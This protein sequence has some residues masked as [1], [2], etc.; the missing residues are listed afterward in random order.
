[1]TAVVAVGVLAGGTDNQLP[2]AL[3]VV[4]LGAFLG[5][6]FINL[7][8]EKEDVRFL[9]TI[10]LLGITLR[11]LIALVTH[12]FLPHG[13]FALD[14][15]RYNQVGLQL[16]A[17]WRNEGSF[18]SY[19]EHTS[20]VGWYYVNGAIY[21][22][23]G[24]VPLVPAF[25][26]CLIGPLSALFIFYLCRAIFDRKSAVAAS[27]LAMFFP[28]IMLWASIN[29]KDALTAFCI[30]MVLWKTLQLQRQ[31]TVS[32]FLFL[33]FFITLLGTL[34]SYLFVLTGASVVGSLMI[35]RLQVSPRGL[36]L[37]LLLM[38]A[39]VGVYNRYGFGSEMMEAE[40]L[41]TVSYLRSSMAEGGSAYAVDAE[42]ETPMQALSYL[43]KG[44]A[45]FLLAP[46]PWQ[47]FNLR[48]ALTF[49]EMLLWYALLPMVWR[50]IRY[51]LRFHFRESV[52]L[53]S[54]AVMITLAYALVESN[55]G[56][57]Y[58]HRAQVLMVY[59]IFAGLGI[60]H[61]KLGP[62]KRETPLTQLSLG[63]RR[64][65]PA[66]LGPTPAGGEIQ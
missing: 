5:L 50:G 54:F 11:C 43:P 51:S 38:L 56:T 59:L 20:Q 19:I 27:L 3:A 34:R 37:G 23:F 57:A 8:S 40:G 63:T 24:F 25:L 41:K 35:G 47:I 15:G 48:Q 16:A 17:H 28:S 4:G 52:I 14:D 49:P 44:L 55:L 29:L 18:P 33:V 39:F 31:F 30:I 61:R 21:W 45:Y 10:F 64:A 12:Y 7:R 62:A 46:A 13:T 26:N 32:N 6:L 60:V 1:M 9:C 42:I 53:L 65:V 58:R 22:L 66:G 2:L 36:L